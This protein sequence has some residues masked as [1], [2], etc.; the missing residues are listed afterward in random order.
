M[1]SDGLVIGVDS[2]RNRKFIGSTEPIKVGEVL[3]IPVENWWGGADE[4]FYCKDPGS[5]CMASIP[6]TSAAC[7][8]P[9]P[10]YGILHWYCT[11]VARHSGPHIAHLGSAEVI[12]SW[13]EK[14]L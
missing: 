1:T 6:C 5:R 3:T 11:R 4:I 9:N 10:I 13:E 12:C 8:L 2:D 14:N 7:R